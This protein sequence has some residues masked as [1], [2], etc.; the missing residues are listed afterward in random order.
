MILALPSV[1]LLDYQKPLNMPAQG[2]NAGER[3]CPNAKAAKNF[4]KF[5]ELPKEMRVNIWLEAFLE[6]NHDRTVVLNGTFIGLP[7]PGDVGAG[8]ASALRLW[9][10]GRQTV[11]VGK[12]LAG[13][14]HLQLACP[15]S[16]EEYC[17][18]YSMALPV[19]GKLSRHASLGLNGS[20][21][22]TRVATGGTMPSPRGWVRL[23]HEFDLFQIHNDLHVAD[24]SFLHWGTS[25]DFVLRTFYVAAGP[26]TPAQTTRIQHVAV[27]NWGAL[28]SVPVAH[29]SFLKDA[30]A[31]LTDP[32][33]E[34][35]LGG[36]RS[37]VDVFLDER[38]YH[39][40]QASEARGSC[41][42]KELV[43]WHQGQNLQRFPRRPSPPEEQAPEEEEDEAGH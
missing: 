30:E 17:R 2:A 32:T 42:A 36:V 13:P 3:A 38:V 33:L 25:K 35:L 39:P 34:I 10:L 29:P 41:F 18:A 6:A 43:E 28:P 20:K 9:Q 15:E 16:R 40:L 7:P 4:P 5:S 26:L 21:A 23:S 8:D 37:R 11:R 14:L 31:A 27:V 24:G 19:Y 22:L 12:H 1:N